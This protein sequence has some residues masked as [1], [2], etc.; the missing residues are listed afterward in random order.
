VRGHGD[1]AG[2]RGLAIT[3]DEVLNQV[4]DSLQRE[5]R[6]SYRALRRRFDL[7]AE[8]LEDLSAE[9]LDAKYLAVD[10]DGKVLVWMALFG[11]PLAHE[12]HAVRAC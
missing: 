9:V 2:R 11:A 10:E 7:D 5:G 8:C 3:F 6:V 12:D 4:L 1:R